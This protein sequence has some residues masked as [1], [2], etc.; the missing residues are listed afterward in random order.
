[1]KGVLGNFA[2]AFL[3]KQNDNSSFL[4]QEDLRQ[5][6]KLMETVVG[7]SNSAR[8]TNEVSVAVNKQRIESISLLMEK[9][10][11]FSLGI[12][13]QGDS[14]TVQGQRGRHTRRHTYPGN[15]SKNK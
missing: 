7:Y 9:C 8:K 2:R 12:V 13:D 15:T 14:C 6:R 1:M 3:L 10:S 4:R 11:H 5:F